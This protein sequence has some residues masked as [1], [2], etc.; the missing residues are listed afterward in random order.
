MT[1]FRSGS[2][3]AGG[4]E[5]SRNQFPFATIFFIYAPNDDQSICSGSILS[6]HYVLSAA[7]CFTNLASADL[8]AGV[9]NVET[10]FPIYEL[11]IFNSDIIIHESYDR[12]RYTN[13]IAVIST[14]RSPFSFTR[15][16]IQPINIIPRSYANSNLTGYMARI[17]GWGLTSDTS[18]ISPVPRYID[19]PIISNDECARTFGT[20]ITSGNICLSGSN[21]RSTCPGDSGGG[22]TIA[23]GSTRVLA[24]IVSF[25]S[26]RGCTLGYP[27]AKTRITAFYDWI[28][29]KT[30]IVIS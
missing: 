10:E 28:T 27:T 11:T 12:V 3:I 14:R 7:H 6:A 26:D 20:L 4:T 30:G 16:E 9:H 18:S 17:S 19:A 2:R 5:A 8:L 25:G 13:D 24:G 21:G 22:M 1:N 29:S 23:H 15:I